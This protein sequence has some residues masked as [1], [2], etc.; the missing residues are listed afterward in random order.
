M[1]WGGDGGLV[2]VEGQHDEQPVTAAKVPDG[3]EGGVSPEDGGED[4]DVDDYHHGGRQQD[5]EA[6]KHLGEE[7]VRMD[8]VHGDE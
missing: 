4:E 1:S 6:D 7:R 8:N 3:P 5:H 2:V